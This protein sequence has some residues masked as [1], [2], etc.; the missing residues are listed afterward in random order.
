MD[1]T[2]FLLVIKI[3][4]YFLAFCIVLGLIEPWRA[5]WWAERQNRLLVLKYYGIPLVLLIIVL[6]MVD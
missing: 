6:L 5:L 2:F 3:T 4:I 1:T